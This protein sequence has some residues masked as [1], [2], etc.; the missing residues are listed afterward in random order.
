MSPNIIVKKDQ[1]IELTLLS[2]VPGIG[3]KGQTVGQFA[4][5]PSDVR[6]AEEMTSYIAGYK[7][8]G[9]MA[10]ELSPLTYV[11]FEEDKYRVFNSNN[12]FE[13]V[14]VEASDQGQV[15]EIDPESSLQTYKTRVYALGSFIP[16]NTKDQAR[17]DARQAALRRIENALALA[18]EKRVIDLLIDPNSWA[19][20]NREAISA[21]SEWDD[22]TPGDPVADIQERI[23]ASWG[24]VDLVGIDTPTAH[25]FIRNQYVKEHQAQFYG[26]NPPS[27]QEAKAIATMGLHRFTIPGL[28]PIVTVPAQY[29]LAGVKT[30]M[31]SDNCL[32]LQTGGPVDMESIQTSKTFRLRGDSANGY[33]VREYFVDGRGLRGGTMIVAGYAEVTVMVS[34]K[35][36]GLI[37]NC[38][39]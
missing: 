32:V 33:L 37:T 12:A 35:V 29:S 6:E 15:A 28:P 13:M 31:L 18:R 10:D 25:R 14:D 1:E 26:H 30:S 17:Y 27:M 4:L 34:N 8:F 23:E 39:A 16:A 11:D 36:G 2:D 38:R 7:P 21:G 20:T 9:F 24:G 19:S 3:K 22:A 5:K